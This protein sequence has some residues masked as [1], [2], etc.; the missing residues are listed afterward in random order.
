MLWLWILTALAFS[1]LLMMVVLP[2]FRV[3]ILVFSSKIKTE[4]NL[5]KLLKKER[6]ILGLAG[7]NIKALLVIPPKPYFDSLLTSDLDVS[8]TKNPLQVGLETQTML[9]L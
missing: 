9:T 6:E 3:I 2:S 1:P 4:T 5:Q 7:K 8:I